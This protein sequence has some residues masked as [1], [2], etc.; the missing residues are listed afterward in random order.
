MGEILAQA[1]HQHQ[2]AVGHGTQG[3]GAKVLRSVLR[4]MGP[5]VTWQQSY[6]TDD[7]VLEHAQKGGFPANQISK[8]STVIDAATAE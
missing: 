1:I 7:N 6:V 2:L 8:V 4:E 3:R 5:R